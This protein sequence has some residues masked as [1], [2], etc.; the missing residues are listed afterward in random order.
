MH[1]SWEEELTRAAMARRCAHRCQERSLCSRENKEREALFC[2]KIERGR[3]KEEYD[4]VR[5]LSTD[6][7]GVKRTARKWRPRRELEGA[8]SRSPFAR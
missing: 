6:E 7:K 5:S 2:M 8:C 3:A 1:L 4:T